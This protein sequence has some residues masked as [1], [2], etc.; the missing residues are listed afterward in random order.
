M[1]KNNIELLNSIAVF[2][3]LLVFHARSIKQ[4]SVTLKIKKTCFAIWIFCA[5]SGY[6]FHFFM[7]SWKF[8]FFFEKKVWP[9]NFLYV[10]FHTEGFRSTQSMLWRIEEYAMY[11]VFMQIPWYL[12][13]IWLIVRWGPSSPPALSLLS[14]SRI[15]PYLPPLYRPRTS[16]FCQNNLKILKD[17]KV[18][19][20][21]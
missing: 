1:A 3:C 17:K 15:R 11:Q 7:T 13:Q 10:F 9:T 19:T 5:M 14:I 21:G 2:L 4:K 16:G 8:L 20:F 12:C 18:L 6:Q